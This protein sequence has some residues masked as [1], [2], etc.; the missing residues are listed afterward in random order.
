[1]SGPGTSPVVLDKW[2]FALFDRTYADVTIGMEVAADRFVTPDRDWL[3][4][5]VVTFADERAKWNHRAELDV[6]RLRWSKLRTRFLRLVA[7]AYLHISY[8][9]PRAIA[10]DWPGQGPWLR[11]P[12]PLRGAQIYSEIRNVF[13][14]TLRRVSRDARI[15][16]W[17]VVLLAPLS[18]PMLAPFGTWMLHLRQAAWD[19]AAILATYPNRPSREQAMA[20]AMCAALEDVS[21]FRPWTGALLEPPHQVLYAS[22]WSSLLALLLGL[23]PYFRDFLL[24]ATA[25]GLVSG[26]QQLQYRRALRSAE[27]ALFAD[28]FARR[29]LAYLDVAVRSPEEF[30]G[31]L[32]AIRRSPGLGSREDGSTA[33]FG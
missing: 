2:F 30:P 16:G 33:P 17:L 26:F 9:L 11:G 15:S 23:G 5:L 12:D 29:L 7:G 32:A 20:Q 6:Y 8:D 28:Q 3:L 18:R 14:Q 1:M 10:D 31:Y 4:R 27:S 21:D 19:H 22:I 25:A 13:P 24:A